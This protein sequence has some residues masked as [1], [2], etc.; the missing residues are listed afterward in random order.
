MKTDFF[1][2]SF[3]RMMEFEIEILGSLNDW[4]KSLKIFKKLKSCSV[5]LLFF[6]QGFKIIEKRIRNIS[7]K[8]LI[9]WNGR[10]KSILIEIY[11]YYSIL[12]NFNTKIFF[13]FENVQS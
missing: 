6:F 9:G 1:S 4:F 2:K 3:Q 8:H 12:I 13:F 7:P 10:E 11:S 5:S